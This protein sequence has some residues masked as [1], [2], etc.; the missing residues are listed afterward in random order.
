MIR[1]VQA[2]ICVGFSN[3]AFIQAA[4]A[5]SCRVCSKYCAQNIKHLS[6][7]LIHST[8]W[9]KP[10]TVSYQRP[11]PWESLIV[12]LL[13]CW[14]EAHRFH[15]N[16]VMMLEDISVHISSETG[17]TGMKID[18]RQEQSEVCLQNFWRK[19][20]SGS[21]LWAW[22]L[23]LTSEVYNPSF[24]SL[25]LHWFLTNLARTWVT[26][27]EHGNEVHFLSEVFQHCPIFEVLTP[28]LEQHVPLS[29]LLLKIAR[30]ITGKHLTDGD[31]LMGIGL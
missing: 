2:L 13:C 21:Y 1:L 12:L 23:L 17:L 27:P 22:K 14:W 31:K 16:I 11:S 19:Y 24:W 9:H 26:F 5:S 25:H 3:V 29:P 10:L 30:D 18:R 4:K 6:K 7:Q 15:A 20:P 8:E 28:K